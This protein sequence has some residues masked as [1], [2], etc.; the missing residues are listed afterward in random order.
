MR[1]IVMCYILLMMSHYT[2]S[3]STNVSDILILMRRKLSEW[4]LLFQEKIMM[5][6]GTG[7]ISR[8]RQFTPIHQILTFHLLTLVAMRRK[9]GTS[10]SPTSTKVSS[11]MILPLTHTHTW[12]DSMHHGG[13]KSSELQPSILMRSLQ[14]SILNGPRSKSSNC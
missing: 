11:K 9:S 4:H 14:G 12:L 13:V 2:N 10:E 7:L 5:R 8:E 6:S 1:R 3:K